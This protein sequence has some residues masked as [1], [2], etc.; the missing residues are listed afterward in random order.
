MQK[1]SRDT[2]IY[3]M[4]AQNPPVLYADPGATLLFETRDAG[5]GQIKTGKEAYDSPVKERANPA[6]GPVYING[7][8]PG[9]ILSV[10]IHKIE[11]AERGYM[12]CGKG[13]G[14][15]GQDLEGG[16]I[17]IIHIKDDMAYFSEDIKIP[18]NKMIGVIGTAPAEGSFSC[19]EPGLHGANMDCKEITEGA[20]VLL[21]VNVPGALLA[22]GDLHAV[23]ADGESGVS[24]LEVVGNVTLTVDVI[25]GKN[26]P[27]PMVITPVHVLTIASH[28]DLDIA[29]KT[30]VANMTRYLHENHG[31][32]LY[33]AI[34]L[35]SLA[36]DVKICQLVNPLKTARV[37][38]PKA[39][40]RNLGG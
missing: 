4:N 8:Q 37:E 12:R 21:P 38:M 25:K 26:L 6:T 29:T 35:I 30:A 27:L 19:I 24:G 3:H 40:L 10:C 28:E 32:E 5:D 33:D 31:F 18:L 34:M 11:T 15:L 2:V 39:Y 1:V 17:K 16:A 7:A 20:Q 14:V 23:M 22:L 9:D 36:G 13:K